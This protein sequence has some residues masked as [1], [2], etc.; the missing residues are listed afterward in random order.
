MEAIAYQTRDVLE[1]MEADTG[2][3][4]AS[5]RVDGGASQNGFLMQ[6]QADILDRPVELPENVESTALGAAL[7]A[8]LTAGFWKDEE[9]LR[10]A[11]RLARVYSPEM[12]EATRKKNYDG[13][14]N[15]VAHT[16]T[17]A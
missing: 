15:A 2:V 14:Q 11:H 16:L 5:L 13:W 10:A 8:G 4:M 3:D 12:D 1:A 6:F 7:L 9:E 17:Q